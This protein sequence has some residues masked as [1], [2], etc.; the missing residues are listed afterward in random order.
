MRS[1]WCLPPGTAARR[2]ALAATIDA[3]GSGMVMPVAVTYFVT[4]A[5]LS[6]VQ[7]GLGLSIAG[8]A[9]VVASLP[10]G[11]LVDRLGARAV[12]VAGYLLAASGYLLYAVVTSFWLFVA[13]TCL[14]RAALRL[15][16]PARGALVAA[17]VPAEQRVETMAFVHGV[18]NA[19]LGAGAVVAAVA[20][21]TGS[22]AAYIGLFLADA[23]SFVVAAAMLQ[24][25]A[26]GR[27]PVN[28]DPAGRADP[29]GDGAAGSAGWRTLLADRRYLLLAAF[30]G[31]LALQH[32]LLP[33]AIPLWLARYGWHS[34]SLPALLY[35]VNT[36][37]VVALQPRLGRAGR[38]TATGVGRYI[39]AGW[40]LTVA[41]LLLAAAPHGGAAVVPLLL[42]AVVSL[43]FG[44]MYS[45]VAQWSASIQL[46]PERLRGRY[47]GAFSAA[48]AVEDLAGPA[49]VTTAVIS[50]DGG[51]LL[52]A[53]V[54]ATAAWG[55]AVIGRH[56]VMAADVG[57]PPA[58]GGPP[59]VV[60]AAAPGSEAP[61]APPA[62]RREAP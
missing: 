7:V 33:L 2:Y 17:A 48:A 37:M 51:W 56:A 25:P 29:A 57:S 20:V 30:S 22:R 44:E 10:A 41:C 55:S 9:G 43:T 28:P 58:V 54:L 3:A 6:P 62:A 38:D 39:P 14:A 1:L 50:V 31:V 59:L 53:A 16:R 42:A 34:G 27:G 49:L 32:N 24:R 23:A 45:G 13:A 5:E 52:L 21:L 4:V 46:A 15:A 8:G 47:L 26:A 36:V 11:A 40:G 19:A 60:P 18:Q 61:Q 35:A 12:L